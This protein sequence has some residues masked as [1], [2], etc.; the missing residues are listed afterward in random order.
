M[1]IHSRANDDQEKYS[2]YKCLLKQ[3][4]QSEPSS[5]IWEK[6]APLPV[7]DSTL[8]TVNGNL[9][10]V[11]GVNSRTKDIILYQ[12]NNMTSWTVISQM[13]TPRSFCLTAALPGNKLMVVGGD[14]T[15]RKCEIATFVYSA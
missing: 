10:A 13:S 1:Y 9:L 3:L 2:V 14:V 12:Y 5:A 7:S 15:L 4:T 11:G 6:I 8:V